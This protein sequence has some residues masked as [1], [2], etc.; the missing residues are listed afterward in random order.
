MDEAEI[1]QGLSAIFQDVFEDPG[2]TLSRE[3]T[4]EDIENWDSARMVD[5]IIGAE[6]R[7]GV[8]FTTRETDGLKCV[9]DFID[10][11]ARKRD[12]AAKS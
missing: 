6:E 2:L 1:T 11:I 7:F 4:A 3:M 5:L 10:L 9:G 8:R 12:S